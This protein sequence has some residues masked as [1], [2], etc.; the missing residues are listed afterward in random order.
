MLYALGHDD[1]LAPANWDDGD[2]TL[3]PSLDLVGKI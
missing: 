3:A 2:D 1:E